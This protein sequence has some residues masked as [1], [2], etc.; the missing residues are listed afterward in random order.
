[1]LILGVEYGVPR[2]IIPILD[3]LIEVANP[4]GQ[5]PVD[6]FIGASIVLWEYTQ[7]HHPVSK[8]DVT[9]VLTDSDRPTG[10]Q[11]HSKT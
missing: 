11:V 4:D 7:Q 5:H 10:A 1:M 6:V 8:Q 9:P 2:D 3:A